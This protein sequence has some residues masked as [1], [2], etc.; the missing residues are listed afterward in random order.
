MGLTLLAVAEGCVPV[1]TEKGYWGVV[2]AVTEGPPPCLPSSYVDPAT[3]EKVEYSKTLSNFIDK[4]LKKN[5]DERFSAK[6]LLDHPFLTTY[7]PVAPR[8]V[9]SSTSE[10]YDAVEDICQKVIQHQ[11]EHSPGGKYKPISTKKLGNLAREMCVPESL[12]I[13]AYSRLER[14]RK[15]RRK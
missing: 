13:D 3:N 12:T 2:Q 5:P 11:I 9:E 15:G 1:S 7:K 10:D 4:C 6:E 8:V 14:G